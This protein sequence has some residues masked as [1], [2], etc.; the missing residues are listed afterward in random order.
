MYKRQGEDDGGVVGRVAG[1]VVGGEVFGL[2]AFEK[3]AHADDGVAVGMRA[4]GDGEEALHDAR[5]RVVTAHVNLAQNHITLAGDLGG[6]ELGRED[7]VGE[8][9]EKERRGFGGAIYIIC[10]LYTSRCV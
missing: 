6:V 10:L 3:G 5:L 1:G 9:I 7:H 2:E 4:E 8:D